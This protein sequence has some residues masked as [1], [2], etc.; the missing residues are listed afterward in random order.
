M[1]LMLAEDSKRRKMWDRSYAPTIAPQQT[2]GQP[3][4]VDKPLDQEISWEQKSWHGGL[5][6]ENDYKGQGVVYCESG[7]TR[8]KNKILMPP[9]VN[10][11]TSTARHTPVNYD[12]ETWTD[13]TTLNSWTAANMTTN[14][15]TATPTP[16]AGTYCAKLTRTT[17]GAV[18]TLKQTN[19]LRGLGVITF[20][21]K[22][23]QTTAQ[24]GSLVRVGLK[25]STGATTFGEY[26]ATVDAWTDITVTKTFDAASTL[27][28]FWIEIKDQA[29]FAYVDTSSCTISILEYA[30]IKF[31]EHKTY[32]LLLLTKAL[33]K[34]DNTNSWWE[35]LRGA[36][37]NSFTDV[38]TFGGGIYLAHGDSV[39][40]EYSTDDGVTWTDSTLAANMWTYFRTYGNYLWGFSAHNNLKTH[41]DPVNTGGAWGTLI[42]VG[43]GSWHINGV[44]GLGNKVLVGK[45]NEVLQIDSTPAVT[46]LMPEF[47]TLQDADNFKGMYTWQGYV[48]LPVMGGLYVYDGTS[49]QD[50]SVTK[51]SVNSL[52]YGHSTAMYNVLAGDSQWL[53]V[54]TSD[55]YLYGLR[56]ET[57]EG[58]V[59]ETDWRWH[60][61][62]KTTYLKTEASV[63]IT[64]VYCAIVSKLQ[65]D[66]GR[67]WFWEYNGTIYN[68]SY[69]ILPGANPPDNTSI[70]TYL[71]SAGYVYTPWWDYGF[72]QVDKA[73]LSLS[74]KCKGA[75]GTGANQMYVSCYYAVDN[76]SLIPCG[77]VGQLLTNT[78]FETGDPPTGWTKYGDG[79][80]WAQSTEQ[81]KSGTYSGKLT[82]VGVTCYAAQAY[83][84]Y[85]SYKSITVSAGCWVYATVAS[86]AYITITDGVGTGSSSYHSGVAGWEYL[87]AS[88]AVSSSAT[89]LWINL[90]LVT[91][92]TS[93]YFDDATLY[94]PSM[95][96]I[97]TYPQTLYFSNL[98][99]KKIRFAFQ[100][101]K[102]AS[103]AATSTLVLES[104]TLKADFRPVPLRQW[105]VGVR[106]SDNLTLYNDAKESQSAALIASNLATLVSET[107]PITM[108]DIDQTSFTCKIIPQSY[109]EIIV[110][111]ETQR[112]KERVATFTMI[113]SKTA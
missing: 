18:G 71:S 109:R 23:Y 110:A 45:E 64:V 93:A 3:T 14:R 49:I 88:L 97:T 65:A 9:R 7:D 86:R 111:D 62:Y 72:S 102:G 39:A 56:L 25:D 40:Y 84:D 63:A 75:N 52:G 16:N 78:S 32:L 61:I 10:T 107:W 36:G 30:G 46:P 98:T 89:K 69:I 58:T 15:T 80:T 95:G 81:A 54:L 22:V 4:D 83:A 113:E 67:L 112:N 1:G 53:Y 85:A 74:V 103:V 96:N 41:A 90:V 5:V 8:W 66:T 55:G 27:E 26:T 91:G 104:F 79:A 43:D 106:I 24:G 51:K 35:V 105:N 31:L 21:V 29:N 34:W 37:T 33:L 82:R 57:I 47:R 38:E 60:L 28:E 20:T 59:P 17:G 87:T 48:F 100:L 77:T 94:A 70:C 11:I 19:Y 42:N 68:A 6:G 12:F 50:I 108:V 99:G 13:A 44:T 2:V 73:F 92:D 76:G 101:I